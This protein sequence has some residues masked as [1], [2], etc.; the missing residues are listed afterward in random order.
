MR[1]FSSAVCDSVPLY[2]YM[3]LLKMIPV[4]Q[5]YKNLVVFLG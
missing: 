5:K 3:T 4:A 1:A 2:K